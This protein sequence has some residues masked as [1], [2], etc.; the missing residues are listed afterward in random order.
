MMTHTWSLCCPTPT[1]TRTTPAGRSEKECDGQDSL[2]VKANVNEEYLEAFRTKSYIEICNKAQGQLGRTIRRSP[3]LSSNNNSPSTNSS[4]STLPFCKHLTEFLLDP[5]Q[6]NITSVAETTKVHH[7]LVNYFES[8]LEA[9]HCCD[10]ILQGL[11]SMRLSYRRIKR[12]VK[13]SKMVLDEDCN[14][15]GDQQ[16]QIQKDVIYRELASFALQNNPLSIQFHDIHQRFMELLHRLRSKRVK[17]QRKLTWKSICKKVAGIGLVTAHSAIVVALLVLCFHSIVG[18]VAAPGILGGLVGWLIKRIF[19]GKNS[20][21]GRIRRSYCERLCEQLD[22]AAKGIY[23]V[24]NELNTVSR[25]VMRLHD[26]V[27]HRRVIAQVCVRNYGKSEILRQVLRDLN[28][29]QSSFLDQL[30]ELE[31]HIYFCFLTI[32]RS[33]S[34]LLQEITQDL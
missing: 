21:N 17:I 18:L 14:N 32:N 10:Q 5:R 24:I 33:R 26:E 13:I 16:Q 15:N 11:H 4:S 20:K 12:V 25:M 28:D 8:S 22:V 31:N 30:E 6:E 27:E 29:N 19:K 7:L 1:L 23:I 34:L 2:C 9:C 3:L